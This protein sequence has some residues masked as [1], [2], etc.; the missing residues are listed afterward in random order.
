MHVCIGIYIRMY[1]CMYDMCVRMYACMYTCMYA[2]MHVCIHVC[3]HVC[4]YVLMYECMYARTHVCIYI[5]TYACMHFNRL[6]ILY[7]YFYFARISKPNL[8][9]NL[10]GQPFN[11]CYNSGMIAIFVITQVKVKDI[12]IISL[13]IISTSNMQTFILIF[14]T[15]S[16][17]NCN[18]FC[19]LCCLS[20]FA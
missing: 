8:I 17:S 1:A 2:C 15:R 10:F 7:L 3:T 9:K 13:T 4:M 5:Y 12:I 20:K 6:T 16:F 14:N 11:F 18:G 19:W